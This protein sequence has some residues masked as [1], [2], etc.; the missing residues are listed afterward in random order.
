MRCFCCEYRQDYIGEGSAY[1]EEDSCSL[2]YLT[3]EHEQTENRNGEIGCVFNKKT[4][5]KRKRLLDKM[6]ES[7]QK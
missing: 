3:N 5:D 2:C 4:L 6:Y 1:F 7:E